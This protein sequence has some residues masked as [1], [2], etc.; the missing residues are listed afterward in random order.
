[1][2]IRFGAALRRSSAVS[3]PGADCRFSTPGARPTTTNAVLVIDLSQA[4]DDVDRVILTRLHTLAQPEAAIDTALLASHEMRR[5]AGLLAGII[6]AAEPV[7]G[8]PAAVDNGLLGDRDSRLDA[9]DVGDGV[10]QRRAPHGALRNGRALVDDG[11]G[12]FAAAHATTATAIG[13][14]KQERELFDTRVDLDVE[15]A[16]RP[17]EDGA[18]HDGQEQHDRRG[19]ED[20]ECCQHWVLSRLIPSSDS[21]SWV[22]AFF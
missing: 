6:G 20:G 14:G 11:L 4:V 16:V 10:R 17:T 9:H 13:A 8:M 2:R 21:R 5:A 12:V 15:C 1:M 18:H 19:P 3:T 22:A 7:R